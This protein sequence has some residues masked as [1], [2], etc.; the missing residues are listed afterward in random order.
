MTF[1]QG[2]LICAS[3]NLLMLLPSLLIVF[4]FLKLH[5]HTMIIYYLFIYLFIYL[6][7]EYEYIHG[8][9]NGICYGM[10]TYMVK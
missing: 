10:N 3:I 2:S 6:L 1:V 9:I 8:G 7:I 4:P 5:V